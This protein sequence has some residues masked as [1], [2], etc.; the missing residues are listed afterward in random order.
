M[1]AVV[2]STFRFLLIIS[3]PKVFEA[4]LFSHIYPGWLGFWTCGW[5][6]QAWGLGKT[7]ASA[8]NLTLAL[9]ITFA[10]TKTASP[11]K[12]KRKCW[13]ASGG[14]L[15]FASFDFSFSHTRIAR[16]LLPPRR[17][18]ERRRAKRQSIAVL[19]GDFISSIREGEN[20]S[21]IFWGK[22]GMGWRTGHQTGNGGWHSCTAWHTCVRVCVCVCN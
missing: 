2:P 10:H 7:T 11:N 13:Y 19:A 15:R 5:G 20:G 17:A 9:D 14:G 12:T 22:D 1:V 8:R 21:G 3:S 16:F 6:I 18:E 4:H